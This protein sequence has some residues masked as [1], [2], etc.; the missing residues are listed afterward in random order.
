M[1]PIV[2]IRNSELA[3][4]NIEKT[5]K[6]WTM[7][8]L[9]RGF[10]ITYINGKAVNDISQLEESTKINIVLFNGTIDSSITKSKNKMEDELNY[11]TA[12]EKLLLTNYLKK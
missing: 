7:N 11:R 9:K 2:Y 12:F 8:I 10:S 6:S 5:S 3:L 1:Q 4:E